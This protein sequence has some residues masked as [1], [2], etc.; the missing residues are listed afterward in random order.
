MSNSQVFEPAHFPADKE[1]EPGQ[2]NFVIEDEEILSIRKD[3]I[4]LR[5]RLITKDT[6]VVEGLRDFVQRVTGRKK[7][8]CICGCHEETK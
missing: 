5:G 8:S 3:G 7:P 2:I 1:I 4:Y 6:E